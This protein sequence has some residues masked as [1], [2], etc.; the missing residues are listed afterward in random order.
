L[1]VAKN[2]CRRTKQEKK[3]VNAILTTRRVLKYRIEVRDG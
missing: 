1:M 2:K 3:K